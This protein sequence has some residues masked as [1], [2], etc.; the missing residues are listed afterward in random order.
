M[1]AV[2]RPL[3]VRATL[4][5]A[6]ELWWRDFAP[7]T[8]LAT[9]LVIWPGFVARVWGVSRFGVAPGTEPYVVTIA[10]TA[11]GLSF[12]LYMSAVSFPLVAAAI[13]EPMR[14]R[15]FLLY[16]LA[17]ARRGLV[18]ATILGVGVV[19]SAIVALLADRAGLGPVGDIL[20]QAGLITVGLGLPAIPMAILERR[21][22]LDA[23]DRTERLIRGNADRLAMVMAA[24]LLAL[25]A[26]SHLTRA[27]DP[28]V[29]AI[30][31]V[32]QARYWIAEL[33]TLVAL[34]P[35]AALPAATYMQ[36]KRSNPRY[37]E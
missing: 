33:L 9:M 20:L 10:Q 32:W 4:R 21:D 2:P 27:I 12:M 1:R 8:A 7:M 6:I 31:D 13:D 14:P 11:L 3:P 17:S 5:L 36:L 16:G 29:R 15:A 26:F 37:R 35:L 22:G 34:G 28:G 24:A 25:I 19:I 18:V 23:F 30:G